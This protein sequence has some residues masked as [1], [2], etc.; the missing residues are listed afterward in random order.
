MKELKTDICALTETWIRED[1]R[2]KRHIEDFENLSGYS[3][4]RKDCLDRRGGGVAICFNPDTI[5]MVP[6]NTMNTR[7]E[8]VTAIGQRVGQRRKVVTI[9]CM[10]VCM[11]V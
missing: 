4:I 11:Y 3:M 9:V 6:V 10:Y 5:S 1:E 2:I 8:I 7:H